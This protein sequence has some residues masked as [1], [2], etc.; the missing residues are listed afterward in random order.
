[1]ARRARRKAGAGAIILRILVVIVLSA[2]VGIGSFAGS[3]AFF[4]NRLKK[5]KKD[6]I[7]EALK[8]ESQERVDVSLVR[9]K[10]A[11]CIRIYHN[12]DKQMIFVPVRKDTILT[13]DNDGVKAMGGDNK[14]ATVEELAAK[15]KDIKVIKAQVEKTFGITIGNYES[16]SQKNFTKAINNSG[17]VELNLDSEVSYKDQNKMLVH[18]PEG[19]NTINGNQALGLILDSSQFSN[20]DDHITLVGDLITKIAQ[21]ITKKSLSDYKSFVKTYYNDYAKSNVSYDSIKD[22]LSRMHEISSKDFTYQILPGTDEGEN[23]KL[24]TKKTKEM[25]D[26]LLSENGEV[27]ESATTETSAKKDTTTTEK[28]K[29]TEVSSK[30]ISI[31][32]QNS[33]RISGL[34]GSWR[35]KLSGD[36]FTVGSVKTN[37]QGALTDTKIIVAKKGMGEDL[38]KYFKNPSIEVGSVASGAQICIILG[39]NDD[40]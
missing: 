36:G 34:A 4:L 10:D 15:V 2:A 14:T 28:K 18:I 3:K 5:D 30:G 32:I 21:S 25:F 20:E 16:L 23:F 35:D 39:S 22:S 29:S 7:A 9:V 27:P 12:K 40:I 24:D 31:E 26:E 8:A 33:T 17:E 38:K 11:L 19:N 37:R 1:M 13:L 6:K